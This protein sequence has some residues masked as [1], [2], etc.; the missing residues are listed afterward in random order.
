MPYEFTVRTSDVS[1]AGTDADVYAAL[2]SVDGWSS[3]Q[4]SL[5]PLKA[6][7]KTKF[8]RGSVD[9]FVVEVRNVVLHIATSYS[10]KHRWRTLA[11]K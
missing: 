3:A 9:K 10:L 4:V 7:R 11:R 2:F 8:N 6:E 5:C 1:G